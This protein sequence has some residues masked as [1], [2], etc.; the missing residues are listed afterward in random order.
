MD[1]FEKRREQKRESIRR[2][3][4]GLFQAHGFRKVSIAEIARQAGVSQ[5][6][7]Y[8]YFGSKEALVA[9]VIKWFILG[10][11]ERYRAVIASDRPFGE[12]LEE[13]VFDKS[14]LASLFQG[15]LL[16]T[17]VK[18]NP[19]IGE[20]VQRLTDEEITPLSRRFF[21]AGI[22]EGYVDKRFSIET[23]MLYLEI[24]RCGFFSN[25]EMADRLSENP[26]VMRE[27]IQLMTY[28]L[29]G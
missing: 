20:F 14:R 13:I 6:T 9:D 15:E 17:Y 29:N 8:N 16:A 18:G 5:V 11:V 28:G 7:I 27:L 21:E 23:I 26:A 19:E 3:A 2:A 22:R 4:L 12:K 24:V 1:G 10:T 25:P